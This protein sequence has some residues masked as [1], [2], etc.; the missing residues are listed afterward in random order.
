MVAPLRAASPC[1]AVW[2]TEGTK[3]TSMVLVGRDG[4]ILDVAGR[5]E[6]FGG[7]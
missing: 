4:D 1:L 3:S 2:Q 6:R 5:R 7:H